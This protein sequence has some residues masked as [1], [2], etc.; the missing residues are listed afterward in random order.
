[1][2]NSNLIHKISSKK[3]N[4]RSLL[5]GFKEISL[6]KSK[7][8][9]LSEQENKSKNSWNLNNKC[10]NK[11]DIYKY[12]FPLLAIHIRIYNVNIFDFLIYFLKHKIY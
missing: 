9:L 2:L 6:V 3:I 10:L 5:S 11:I 1:M 12:Y 7:R 8:L 4:V